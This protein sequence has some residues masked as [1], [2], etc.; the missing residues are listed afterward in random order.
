VSNPLVNFLSP[1]N[2]ACGLLGEA[3]VFLWL[4]VMGVNVSG[5]GGESKPLGQ[6]SVAA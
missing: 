1:Y 4:L 2:L 3:L 6:P 5:V